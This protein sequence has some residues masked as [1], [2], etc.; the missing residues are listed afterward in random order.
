MAERIRSALGVEA[1]LVEGGRGEFAVWVGDEVVAKKGWVRFPA[2][3]KVVA[4]VR[5]A[6]AG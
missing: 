3:E 5:E 4:A 1:E 2:E 6:L